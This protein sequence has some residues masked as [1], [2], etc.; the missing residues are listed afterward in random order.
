MNSDRQALATAVL[1][2]LDLAGMFADWLE[3]HGEAYTGTLLRRRWNRWLRDRDGTGRADLRHH[4]RFHVD[5]QFRRYVANLDRDVD[6]S[7]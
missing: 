5:C 7:R 2:N 4:W 6:A 3:E 1:E